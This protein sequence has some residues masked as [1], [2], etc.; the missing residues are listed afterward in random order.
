MAVNCET[1]NCD[2]IADFFDPMHNQICFSCMEQQIEED[3]DLDYDD[4]EPI[5]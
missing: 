1:E 5:E 2:Y 4:F 3:S